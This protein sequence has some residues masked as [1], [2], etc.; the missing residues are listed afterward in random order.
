MINGVRTSELAELLQRLKTKSGRSYEYI[1]QRVH[2][3][4]SAV[5]RYCTG[6]S[7][8]SRYGV[9][10]DIASV[11]GAS[12]EEMVLL[13]RLWLRAATSTGDVET[14]TTAPAAVTPAP[15][16][17]PA[18][19]APARTT[20]PTTAAQSWPPNPRYWRQLGAATIGVAM[21]LVLLTASGSH[22]R[23]PA[24][25]SQPPGRTVGAAWTLPSAPVPDTLF[26][27]TINSGTGAM[28]A[29]HVGAVRFW[30]GGTRWSEIQ[31][32][33]GEFDWSAADRLVDGAQNAGV[34]ALF[35]FGGTPKW[36]SPAGPAGPYPE[37][38]PAPP[39][40]LADWDTY[41]RTVVERY[42]GRIQAY[43]LWVLANDPR[44]YAGSVETLVEMTRRAGEIIRSTDHDATVVCPGMGRL[45]DADGVE[46][47][48]RFAALGGYNHCDVAGVKLFQQTASDPP[49]TM[50]DLTDTIDRVM[51]EAGLQPRLWSTGTMYEITLEHPLDEATARNYAVRFF[52]VGIY[53]RKV[54][55]ERMYFYNWGGTKI[56]IV[57]Q[58]VGGVPTSAA[59]AVEQ[60]QRWLRHARSESCGHGIQVNLPDNVWQCEF[61]ATEDGDAYA[62]VIRWTDTGTA[63]VTAGDRTKE[64]R[65]LDGTVTVVRPGDAITVTE[66]PVLIVSALR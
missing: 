36:A 32:E 29:F 46:F 45:W 34:P 61:I 26:G 8:P 28:P 5:H 65:H 51:H 39:V 47:L 10:E 35:V 57:L 64:V 42:R 48:Q 41:V 58:P 44:F 54:N 40:D 43:E 23:E 22:D 20:A 2:L 31:R 11:C 63:T 14:R 62:A 33:R 55:L 17:A 56:P 18:I 38:T 37:G 27:V 59:L 53:A 9:V 13:H 7:V 3:S 12:P 6:A 52:L 30:D 66:E 25:A 21:I 4:K 15:T 50:L 19:A 16:T 49:E 24:S 60:L 1:G